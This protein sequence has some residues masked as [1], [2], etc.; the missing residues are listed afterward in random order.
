SMNKRERVF[1]AVKGQPVDRV[2]FSMWL[3]DFTREHSAQA[4]SEETLRLYRTYGWDFLKPQSRPYCFNELW[5]QEFAR[6]TDPGQFP[7][8]TRYGVERA[9]DIADLPAVDASVGALAEQLES[10]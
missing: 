2:P 8:V 10:Y 9:E 3:H 5:G 4:L 1:A 6:S 7:V